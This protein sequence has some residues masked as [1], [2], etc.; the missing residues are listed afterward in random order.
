MYAP[1][2]D[3]RVVQADGD[4]AAQPRHSLYLALSTPTD[5]LF[6]HRYSRLI[7]TLVCGSPLFYGVFFQRD[8]TDEYLRWQ[9]GLQ[10]DPG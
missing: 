7:C 5:D 9:L 4:R 1:T 3:H 2:I 8:E 10:R 6:I